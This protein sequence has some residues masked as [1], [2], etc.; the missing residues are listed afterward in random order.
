MK[1]KHVRPLRL[2]LGIALLLFWEVFPRVGLVDIVFVPPPSRVVATIVREWRVSELGYHTLLSTERALVGFGLATAIG[3]V[4]GLLIAGAWPRLSEAIEPLVELFAQANPVV[5]F[6]IVL[7]FFGI[8]EGAKIFVIAWMCTWPIL[9]SAIGGVRQVDPD[10]VRTTRSFGVNGF[11]LCWKCLLPGAIP[12]ILTGMRLSGGY[13]FIMLVATEMMG[14]SSGLG[15][16]VVQSQESY[17][18]AR[19]FAGATIITALALLLDAALK[20]FEKRLIQWKP[21]FDER[22]VLIED[23]AGIG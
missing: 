21:D 6:H 11:T 12:S 17:H 14:T 5:L 9:F 10:L 13:A 20:R 23:V 7:L 22:R 4:L 16:F 2:A 18:A 3:T 8:G 19:I 1:A 15:W